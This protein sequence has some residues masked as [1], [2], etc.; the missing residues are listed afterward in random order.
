[1]PELLPPVIT[2]RILRVT[3]IGRSKLYELIGCGDIEMIKVGAIP[4][5][6]IE[7]L[8]QFIERCR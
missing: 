5:I 4:L 7:S 1:M 2:V 8:R 6:P 3:G